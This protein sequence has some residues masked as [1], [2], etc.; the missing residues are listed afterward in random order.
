VSRYGRGVLRP[1]G[2]AF[3]IPQPLQIPG[4]A[5]PPLQN[6]C[7]PENRETGNGQQQDRKRY[8]QSKRQ[9]RTN[10][11]K[12][13]VRTAD[14]QGAADQIIGPADVIVQDFQQ[15]KQN[16]YEENPSPV[17]VP[18][19]LE[20]ERGDEGPCKDHK[21]DPAQGEIQRWATLDDPDLLRG[22]EEREWW[23][24]HPVC[25]FEPGDRLVKEEVI[26]ESEQG[27]AEF[28][29][30]HRDV[31]ASIG[32]E[33]CQECRDGEAGDLNKIPGYSGYTPS[34][35][36]SGDHDCISSI[37]NPKIASGIH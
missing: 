29:E 1:V 30:I 15:C 35:G 36:S 10:E 24:V 26:Q 23:N 19:L 14:L 32:R 7:I 25:Y 31:D 4:P 9:D 17:P 22:F 21:D 27:V 2:M 16:R 20:V 6:V 12:P 3:H 28:M 11:E 34:A 8:H 5:L 18:R 33:D 37:P 13:R